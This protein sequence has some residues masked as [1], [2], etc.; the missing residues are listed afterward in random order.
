MAAAVPEAAEQL[1][2]SIR[3]VVDLMMDEPNPNYH[4][5]R[6]SKAVKALMNGEV[7]A[8]GKERMIQLQL[9]SS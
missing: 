9:L 6:E 7:V 1:S 8:T 2:T 4:Q 3:K 5:Y